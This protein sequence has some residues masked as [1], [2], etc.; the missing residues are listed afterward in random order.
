MSTETRR[1]SRNL[2]CRSPQKHY[3]I[4][5]R[6]ESLH[7]V[8]YCK[9]GIVNVVVILYTF[10]R[11][12]SPKNYIIVGANRH[13][14]YFYCKAQ[15]ASH[16][17]IEPLLL[18]CAKHHILLLLMHRRESPTIIYCNVWLYW[19]YYL[20][21]YIYYYRRLGSSWPAVL[22]HNCEFYFIFIIILQLK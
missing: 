10:V 16:I 3:S 9:T 7:I 6:R 11:R 22:R 1:F 21:Y 12:K 19:V 18:S 14:L 4:Y 17:I 5:R 15:I 20:F 13:I 8:Y 2:V